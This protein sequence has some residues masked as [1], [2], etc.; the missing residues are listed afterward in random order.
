MQTTP[1]L[2]CHHRPRRSPTARRDDIDV[3]SVTVQPSGLRACVGGQG[4][5]LGNERGPMSGGGRGKLWHRC[6]SGQ[7][8]ALISAHWPNERARRPRATSRATIANRGDTYYLFMKDYWYDEYTR[9]LCGVVGTKDFVHWKSA[10]HTRR[11]AAY[12]TLNRRACSQAPASLV[13]IRPRRDLR[14]GRWRVCEYP[15]VPLESEVPNADR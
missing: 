1:R 11:R 4:G 8:D 15:N 9:G 13:H 6:F 2:N 3:A 10:I 7:R 12:D 14:R 5:P